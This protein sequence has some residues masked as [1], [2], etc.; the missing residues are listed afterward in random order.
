[1]GIRCRR[2]P[3]RLLCEGLSACASLESLQLAYMELT[4]AD[5][6]DATF[7]ESSDELVMPFRRLKEVQICSPW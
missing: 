6:N 5:T 4:E 7:D 2:V 3:L 1:M